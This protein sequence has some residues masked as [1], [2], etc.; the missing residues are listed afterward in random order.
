MAVQSVGVP[1]WVFP[2]VA[3]MDMLGLSDWVVA[4]SEVTVPNESRMMAHDRIPPGGYLDCFKPNVLLVEREASVTYRKRPL[5][6]VTIQNCERY[7]RVATTSRMSRVRV[8]E[9]K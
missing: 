8:A 5:E 2:H 6:D 9:K 3:I 7:Y 1:G 4:R